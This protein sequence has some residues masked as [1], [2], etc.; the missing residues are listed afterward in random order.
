MAGLKA[1]DEAI[2]CLKK[3]QD[4]VFRVDKFGGRKTPN[5]NKDVVQ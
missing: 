3:T 4:K 1:K 2:Q 5:D